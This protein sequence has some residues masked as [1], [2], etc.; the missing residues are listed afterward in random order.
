MKR[1]CH[2]T[3]VHQPFDVRIFQKMAR[4]LAKAGYDVVL[5]APHTQNETV[6]GVRIE[7][8]P[9]ARHRIERWLSSRKQALYQ[10]L[11][12]GAD[13]YHFHDPELIPVGLALKAQGKTVVYDVHESHAES[14]LDRAYIPAPLRRFVSANV[15]RLE[16]QADRKLDAIVAA[17]PKIGRA[18]TNLRTVLVQNYPLAGELEAPIEAPFADR[19]RAVVFVGGVSAARG[20][21][22]MVRA[23]DQTRDVR[24][25][26]VGPFTPA[27]L[28]AELRQE[29]G[30]RNVEA[31][32]WQDR[33]AVAA[34]MARA[35]T[36]LV[37]FHPMRNHVESQPN[38]LF[39]YMSAGLPVIGSDFPYWRELLT[40]EGGEPVGVP[41]DPLD[42]T[43]VAEA[44]QR[45]V[46]D[47]GF[48]ESLG[49]NGRR[50][51][52]E[53]F[54]WATQEQV[55]LNLYRDLLPR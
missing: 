29:P 55:L 54:N 34:A 53:K 10:A 14:I 13:L 41:V 20:A 15:A 23:M 25:I 17:T 48:A 28:E 35:R 12:V 38:K 44:V 39:E 7:A 22:E 9:K 31:L 27:A 50:A 5:L 3:T 42:P 1:V 11:G 51:V 30:W 36:G 8:L 52:A 43:K 24:L 4:G 18:F 26:L 33:P 2:I 40:P 37:L 49:Q 45:L 32:G 16:R 46:D 21:R 47:P 6:D 19:E